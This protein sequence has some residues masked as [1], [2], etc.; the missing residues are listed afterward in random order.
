MKQRFGKKKGIISR[1]CSNCGGDLGDRYGKQK[2]CKSCHAA[3]MRKNR[4]K[5]SELSDLQRLKIKCRARFNV[6][7]QRGKISKQPCKVCGFTKAEAHHGDY[8][9]PF[10]VVWLCRKHHLEL[11]G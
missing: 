6:S 10:E 8:T 7:I 4:P 2:Y 9:K 5:Y 11:H 3:W 1:A